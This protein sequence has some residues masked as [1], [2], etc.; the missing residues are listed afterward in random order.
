MSSVGL[1]LINGV[2]RQQTIGTS[3]PTIYDQSVNIV[4][5][6]GSAPS[7]LNAPVSAG[8][9]VTLPSSGSY[10]LNT[11]SYP[12]LQVFLN[13]DRLEYLLDWAT[14]GSGPTYTAIQFTFN[15]E[16]ADRIDFRIDRNS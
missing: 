12:N 2:P 9:A 5:S 3:L 6:G 13:G 16:A 10:T 8:T 4:T 15:L 14:S 11:N 1:Q 7:S